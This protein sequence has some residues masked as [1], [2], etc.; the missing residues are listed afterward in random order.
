[1]D[2]GDGWIK[3]KDRF[4]VRVSA[5]VLR[6]QE[7][8]QAVR[9]TNFSDGGC[10]IEGSYGLTVGERVRIDIPRMGAVKAQ[11]RWALG[12]CAGARFVIEA[13]L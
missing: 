7:R 13:D 11:I 2:R 10:R 12:N 1:M 9:L 3:R 5:V 4:P 6:A 8:S